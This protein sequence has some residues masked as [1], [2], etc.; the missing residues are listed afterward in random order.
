MYIINKEVEKMKKR[1]IKQ[2]KKNIFFVVVG[3][4]TTMLLLYA[5]ILQ[6][7]IKILLYI[8]NN[9]ITTIK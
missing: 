4:I 9:C 2:N 3:R 7:S 5:I 1:R 6:V 8:V